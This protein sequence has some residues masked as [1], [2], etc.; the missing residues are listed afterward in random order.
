MTNKINYKQL[1]LL[2]TINE[3]TINIY[4][5]L[6]YLIDKQRGRDLLYIYE[7]KYEADKKYEEL[8][9]HF[10]TNIK[11][12]DKRNRFIEFENKKRIYV[13]TI[14]KIRNPIDGYK[15]REI[16]IK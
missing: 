14:N 1:K 2:C 15:F 12:K 7:T 4:R 3:D 13:W 8:L 10:K 11:Y 5:L 6:N 9:E 16:R